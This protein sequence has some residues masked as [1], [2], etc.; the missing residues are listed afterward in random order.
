MKAGGPV[1]LGEPLGLGAPLRPLRL[2]LTRE[3][4]YNMW[5]SA[6][7]VKSGASPRESPGY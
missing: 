4:E 2:D 7:I 6:D 1:G 5:Y 3:K